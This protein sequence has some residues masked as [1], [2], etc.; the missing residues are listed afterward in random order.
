MTKKLDY[1]SNDEL[2]QCKDHL[3]KLRSIKGQSG[4]SINKAQS[5]IDSDRLSDA[6][7][8]IDRQRELNTR[9]SYQITQMERH[10]RAI[11]VLAK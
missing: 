6:L 4:L 11:G 3:V 5:A 1:D 2:L 9:M 8:Q 10:L 7:L